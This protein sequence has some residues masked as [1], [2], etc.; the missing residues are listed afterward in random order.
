MTVDFHKQ[1]E[2][3]IQGGYNPRGHSEPRPIQVI[4]TGD[5]YSSLPNHIAPDTK[6]KNL[7]YSGG[8]RGIN[9]PYIN[10]D[11]V[12]IILRE[13]NTTREHTGKLIDNHGHLTLSSI[14]TKFVLE[15]ELKR[16]TCNGTSWEMSFSFKKH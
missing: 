3:Q 14:G 2:R 15:E 4:R 13:G 8:V 1:R 7:I 16:L 5:S 10:R 11:N 9:Y 12:V 6:K